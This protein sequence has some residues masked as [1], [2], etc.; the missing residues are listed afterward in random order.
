MIYIYC[1]AAY[2]FFV[3]IWNVIWCMRIFQSIID[4]DE[5]DEHIRQIKIRAKA[6]GIDL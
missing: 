6:M 2:I 5:L 4:N 3:A 1:E